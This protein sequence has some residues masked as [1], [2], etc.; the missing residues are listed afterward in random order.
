MPASS[1]WSVLYQ[2]PTRPRSNGMPYCLPSTWYMPRAPGLIVSCQSATSAVMSCT[3]PA[4][5]CSRRPPPPHDWKRS[6]G[7]A[8][9]ESVAS[10]VLNASFSLT[11]R[12]IVT[13]GCS[14]H[15]LVGKVLPEVLPGSLFWMWYQSISRGSRGVAIGAALAASADGSDG[16]ARAAPG[17]TSAEY[18]C[19][20]GERTRHT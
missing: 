14:G 3:R 4:S 20:D 5:T 8:L 15:V 18:E 9:L 19:G 2:K 1:N 12:L 7:V 11:F 17:G 13:L 10:L 16:V 6:G